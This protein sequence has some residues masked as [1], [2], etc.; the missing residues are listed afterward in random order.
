MP[1]TGITV[2]AWVTY[3]DT[4]LGT[5]SPWRW[6]TIVRTGFNGTPNAFNFRVDAGNNG[7]RRLKWTVNANG[8]AQV[9]WTFNSGQM[10]T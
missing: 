6:P 5:S 9:R 1:Q 8:R 10:L 3:D 7:S 2:E 4:T